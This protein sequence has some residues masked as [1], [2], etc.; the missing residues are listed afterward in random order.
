MCAQS[1]S[2]V[3][4]LLNVL[5][6]NGGYVVQLVESYFDES[7]SH[8]GSPVLCVAGYIIDKDECVQLDS[9]W[10]QVLDKYNLPYFRMSC[11]AHGVEPFDALDKTQ[12]IAAETEMITIM[13][14]HIAYGIAI[15]VQP[16]SFYALIPKNENWNDPYTMCAHTCLIAVRDW[17]NM[18]QF[19]GKIAYFFE[20]GHRSQSS[21]NAIMN[22]VFTDPGLKESYRYS[23]HSFAD[24]KDVRPLQAADL[25]AWQW[26]TDEKRRMTK[27]ADR[28]RA[29]CH[30]LMRGE[31][32]ATSK[33]HMLHL[34]PEHLREMARTIMR[35]EYP[36]TYPGV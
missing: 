21:A 13:R 33:Y 36:L 19:S 14:Q 30:E 35:R 32:G 9:K 15:T 18:N 22:H 17:A 8:D 2:L 23:S 29:D 5:L 31:S 24:K 6:Q 20:S 12:R 25:I 16:K 11:C 7:G 34:G 28:P 10:K 3:A 26:F 27:R 1:Q 4:R